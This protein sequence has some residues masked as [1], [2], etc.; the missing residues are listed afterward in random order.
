MYRQCRRDDLMPEAARKGT[1]MH[2]LLIEDDRANYGLASAG[3][4]ERSMSRTE[5]LWVV[6]LSAAF[7][8]ITAVLVVPQ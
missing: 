2:V 4:R 1:G 3:D 8:A 6:A 7:V 5:I